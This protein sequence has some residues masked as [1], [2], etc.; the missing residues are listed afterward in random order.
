MIQVSVCEDNSAKAGTHAT[1]RG[2]YH[3][4]AARQARIHESK[5]IV[6]PNEETINHAKAGKAK[7]VV[8]FLS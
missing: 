3:R 8:R 2:G 6:F 4:G 1:Y 5:A 7:K